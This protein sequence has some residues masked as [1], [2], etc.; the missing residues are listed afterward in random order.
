MHEAYA[1][2]PY[3]HVLESLRQVFVV[4]K[5]TRAARFKGDRNAS[6]TRLP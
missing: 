6:V 5:P 1:V 3:G 4:A 2:K